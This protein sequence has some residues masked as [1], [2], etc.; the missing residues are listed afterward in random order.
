[1]EQRET[2]SGTLYIVATPI[3]NL[4]DITHRALETL[5]AVDLI[6][7]EDT[8][9]TRRLLTAYGIATPITSYHAHTPAKKEA[10]L[11][12]KLAAGASVALVTDA[13]TPGISDPAARLVRRAL[14]A[15]VT[16]IPVPGPTAL[17]AALSASGLPTDTFTFE[18]FLSTKAGRRRR[19]LE[20]LAALGHTVVLYESPRRL[21]K[22][23]VELVETFGPERACVVAREVSKRHEEFIRGAL[24]EVARALADREVKGEVTVL[25][26][27]PP[28]RDRG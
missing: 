1:M 23:L 24:A 15:G 9:V 21:K 4:A 19:R 28:K 25:V 8:R 16:V 6:A 22:L 10:E 13:G 12:R 2:A 3:G 20:A 5:R 7:A 14:E 18:G 17:I 27:P 11:V 26:G